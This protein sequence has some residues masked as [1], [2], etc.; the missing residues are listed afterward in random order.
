MKKIFKLIS[1][2]CIISMLAGCANNSHVEIEI[3]PTS[4]PTAAPT[5]SIAPTEEVKATEAPKATDTP[6]PTATNTPIPTA[7]NTPTPKPTATP[8]PEGEIDRTP[9]WDIV[10]K[11]SVGWNLGNTFDATGKSGL[12]AETYWGQPKT[13]EAMMDFLADA[14]IN[15]IRIP[16]TFAKHIGP[17][18]DYTIDPD[19]LARLKEVV[20]YC[21]NNEQYV[22]LDTHHEPDYWLVPSKEKEEAVTAEL[23]AIWTQVAE[24]FKDYDQHLVFEGMNEPRTKGSAAEWQGGTQEEREVINN[25]NKAF[26]DAVRATGGNN[27]TR[28]LVICP[29]GNS[30]TASSIKNLEVPEDAYI[31]VA[32]HMYTPYTFTYEPTSGSVFY[33]SNDSKWDILGQLRTLKT[34]LMDNGVPVIITEFGA[35][36]KTKKDAEGNIVDNT[37]EVVK[38]L[39]L[40]MSLANEYECPAIWW[41]NNIYS[42]SGEKFGLFN[43]KRL[44][45]YNEDI[46]NKLIEMGNKRINQ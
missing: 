19:W 3:T 15:T 39:E 33:W 17:A 16:V 44:A 28:L 18:P 29:Y 7:T 41:D 14:G 4:T 1:T 5:N 46:A 40:Y 38:W 10:N 31:A 35:V 21:I 9:A 11:M 23:A 13:T 27:E 43:R 45:F 12:A 36:H 34:N 42:T 8:V 26:V 37:Q 20:D 24:Y 2:L 25:L 30:V 6:V 22:L 32:A